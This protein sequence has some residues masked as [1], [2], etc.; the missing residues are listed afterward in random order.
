MSDTPAGPGWWE[1]SDGKW[2][3]PELHPDHRPPPPPVQDSPPAVPG[4]PSPGGGLSDLGPPPADQWVSDAPVPPG[5][6]PPLRYPEAQGRAGGRSTGRILALA[7]GGLFLLLAG[8][9][10]VLVFVFRDEIADAVVDFSEAVVVEE[11]SSCRV[12]GI[13]VSED[14][15]I[16]A[17]LTAVETAV[18]SHFRLDLEVGTDDRVLGIAEAVLRD[19]EPG[20]ERTEDV[21]N[22]IPAVEPVGAVSCRVVRVVRVDA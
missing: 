17:S 12:T 18:T 20:E 5:G 2:Y 6:P 21:F 1:A 7:F 14:Y 16:E 19:V 13:D 15:E 4:A 11:P 10:G 22:T 9:C 3:A 8:G